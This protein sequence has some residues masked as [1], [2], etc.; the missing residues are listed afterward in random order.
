MS[1]EGDMG[2]STQ[3]QKISKKKE[4]VKRKAKREIEVKR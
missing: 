4:G 3:K 1:G 2:R